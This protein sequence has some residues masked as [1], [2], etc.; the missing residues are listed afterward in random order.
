LMTE[1]C[2]ELKR[3]NRSSSSFTM[4]VM[5]SCKLSLSSFYIEKAPTHPEPRTHPTTQGLELE[6]TCFSSILQLD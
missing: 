5:P 4:T 6:S 2:W 1:T 3:S